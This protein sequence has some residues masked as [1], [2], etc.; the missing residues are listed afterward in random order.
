MTV[1]FGCSNDNCQFQESV[2]SIQ[3]FTLE[4]IL[5]VQIDNTLLCFQYTGETS[6]VQLAQGRYTTPRAP[7]GNE[8][9]ENRHSADGKGEGKIEYG[10]KGSVGSA[11]RRY[12][13]RKEIRTGLNMQVTTEQFQGE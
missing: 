7:R 12:G 11:C 4:D 6:E 10:V 13:T 2:S 9:S 3:S 8:L 5:T 1:S